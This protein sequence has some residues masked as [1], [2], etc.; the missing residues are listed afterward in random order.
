M[1]EFKIRCSNIG[2]I[3]KEPKLKADKEAGLLGET[4]KSVVENY[5]LKEQFGFY[6]EVTTD[7]MYKG[8]LVEQ[9]SMALVQK[10]LGGEFRTKCNDYLENEF[11]MGNPDIVLSKVVEDIKSSYTL[12]TFYGSE[13]TDLYEYQG[14]GYMALAGKDKFRLIYCLVDTPAEIIIKLKKRLFYQYDSDEFNLDYIRLSKQIETNHLPSRIPL[15]VLPLH[16]RIKIFEIERDI[17][18]ENKIYEQ[19]KKCRNYYNSLTI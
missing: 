19:V 18:I 5:W 14:R 3:M 13:L 10:V 9:D 15:D 12:R 8:L 4:A 7:E 17:S 11:L 6:E 1:K 16:K 2:N